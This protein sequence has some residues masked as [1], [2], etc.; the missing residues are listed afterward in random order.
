MIQN[1]RQNHKHPKPGKSLICFMSLANTHDIYQGTVLS[2]VQRTSEQYPGIETE[3]LIVDIG[4]ARIADTPERFDIIVCENLY[5]DI[6][7]DITA[8]LSGSVGLCGSANLGENFAMFEAIHGSAPDIAGQDLANPSGMLH[9]AILM[10]QYL[11]LKAQAALLENAWLRT[12]EDGIHT[13]DIESS[14]TQKTVGTQEFASQVAS[15]LGEEPRR[16]PSAKPSGSAQVVPAPQV[17]GGERSLVG[18]DIFI[19]YHGDIGELGEQLSQAGGELELQSISCRGS[20]V[21]PGLHEQVLLTDRLAA[22]FRNPLPIEP[23][24]VVELIGRLVDAQVE[25]VGSEH[26][27]LIDGQEG[28]SA[29]QG[30]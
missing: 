23:R 12:L 10:M 21:F 26:L 28:F 22:R 15:R 3:R 8:Q 27:Y 2:T 19:H 7:S 17:R 20:Q 24:Q 16:L 9:G 13:K 1:G 14:H 11:G 6:L 4:M 29:L 30:E 18:V 25:I 5:G